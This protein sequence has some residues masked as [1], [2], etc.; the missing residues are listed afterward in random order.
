MKIAI[1]RKYDLWVVGYA[2]D[3]SKYEEQLRLNVFP[4]FGGMQDDYAYLEIPY[5][6]YNIE[7]KDGK[8]VV[9]ETDP[10]E[11]V[12]PE[13]PIDPMT[14]FGAEIVK[15]KMNDMNKTLE[16]AKVKSELTRA[17]ETISSL[18]SELTIAKQDILNLK[19]ASG[20]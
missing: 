15:L 1:Y 8:L 18:G 4:N 6:N 9:V 10:P 14:Q 11:P 13:V 19:G 5:D 7:V 3:K 20:S 17:K 12:E 16:L 2:N